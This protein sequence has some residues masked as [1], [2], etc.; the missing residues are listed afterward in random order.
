M[1]RRRVDTRQR[2]IAAAH[3]VF[4]ER[5]IR[6]SPIELVC[7]R[8]GFTRGAFYSN[9]ATKEDL[10][11]A[12]FEQQNE[13]RAQRLRGILAE[14]A[15]SGVVSDMSSVQALVV[16]VGK[17]FMTPLAEDRDWYLLCSEF[18]SQALRQPELRGHLA[19]AQ[20]EF[21][22]RLGQALVESLA[23]LGLRFVIA[24][25]DAVHVMVGMY[26]MAMQRSLLEEQ[27]S[28]AVESYV[29]DLIPR[30]MSALVEL[31]QG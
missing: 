18:R 2:L 31:P 25:A 28:S 30:L 21:D 29:T 4:L 26:E 10:F 17:L 5:G 7:E 23:Q 13:I 8:A 9:F 11:L 24:P 1:T 19:R 27:A 16:Q 22:Q 3:E 20:A 12:L 6:D 15:A 14:V